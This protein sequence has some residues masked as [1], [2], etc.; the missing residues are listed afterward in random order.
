MPSAVFRL[1][2]PQLTR[3]TVHFAAVMAEAGASAGPNAFDDRAFDTK[4][5]AL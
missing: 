4:M 1:T 3:F 5:E 2:Q